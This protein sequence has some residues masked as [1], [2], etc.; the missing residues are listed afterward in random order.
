MQKNEEI[1]ACFFCKCPDTEV[2]GGG[3]VWYVSCPKCGA[4]GPIESSKVRAVKTYNNAEV[5]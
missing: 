1:H 5:R 4:E 2:C 3:S